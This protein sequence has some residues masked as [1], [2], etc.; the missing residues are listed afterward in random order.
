[1]QDRDHPGR[2]Q[3]LDEPLP[4]AV[5]GVQGARMI[6]ADWYGVHRDAKLPSRV[7]QLGLLLDSLSEHDAELVENLARRL[8]N[9]SDRAESESK[10]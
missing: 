1:M 5:A 3:P 9:C 4:M 8:A 6:A 7:L 10:P 2:S